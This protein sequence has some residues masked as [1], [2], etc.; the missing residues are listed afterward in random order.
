[1][2]TAGDFK[3]GITIEW[4]GGVWNIVDF[5]HVK[6]GKG[7]AFVRTKIKNVMTG[8]VV[9]RTFNPTDKMPRAIIDTKEMQYLYND[10][11]LYY[12]MDP[13]TYEQEPL[14]KD[15]V[16]DAVKYVKE[17]MS[18]TIRYFKGK[19]F[20]VEAPNFVDLEVTQTEP[21]FKGDT[22]SNTYKPATVE[23]GYELMV[24]LFINIGDV[25]K[26]DTRSGEYL[27]RA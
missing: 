26:I 3:K 15:A 20:S 2:I 9:E 5:Q 7:A 25:I 11:D 24:P 21:G 14:G 13:E 22:A 10:G 19:A 17:N 23:T 6:P 4:D 1:M 8:A 12:F 18:V 27:S 16:E